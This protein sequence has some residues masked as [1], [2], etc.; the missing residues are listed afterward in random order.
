MAPSV[1]NAKRAAGCDSSRSVQRRDAVHQP[2]ARHHH[3]DAERAAERDRARRAAA[4]RRAAGTRASSARSGRRARG[5]RARRRGTSSRGRRRARARSRSSSRHTAAGISRDEIARRARPRAAADQRD[6]DWSRLKQQRVA[7]LLDR[8]APDAR[9]AAPTR[10]RARVPSGPRRRAYRRRPVRPGPAPRSARPGAGGRPGPACGTHAAARRRAS[11]PCVPRGPT[12]SRAPRNRASRLGATRPSQRFVPTRISPSRACCRSCCSR[13]C[14]SSGMAAGGW[15]CA[16]FVAADPARHRARRGVRQHAERLHR[17]RRR[18]AHGAHAR[19]PAAVGRGSRR[20]PRSLFGLALGVAS[21]VLLA[22]SSAGRSRRALGVASILFYVF[23]YTVWLKPRSAWNAVIGGAAGAAAPLIAD[24]A[25]NGARRR[26]GLA[27][28]AIVFF[29]QPPHVWAIALYRKA[30]LRGA[31]ASRCCPS[32][33]RR[34]ADAPAHA[35]VHA[36]ARAGDARAG[37]ARAARPRSTWRS[38]SA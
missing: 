15:P 21:T 11:R 25:V 29:W 20:A 7:A 8:D 33:D 12:P 30:R 13:A 24:A 28:F 36:R 22:A 9:G 16:G 4:P 6:P 10:A 38:R 1:R 2:D 5:R 37:R 14:R 35:L 3:R 32:R 31:P 23:V 18:R 34:P 27:L 17:A 19:A 26:R